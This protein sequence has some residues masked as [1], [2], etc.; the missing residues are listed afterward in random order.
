MNAFGGYKLSLV[1]IAVYYS[2]NDTLFI[3]ESASRVFN[4]V[5]ETIAGEPVYYLINIIFLLKIKSWDG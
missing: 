2:S 1:L 5:F 4:N 3:N